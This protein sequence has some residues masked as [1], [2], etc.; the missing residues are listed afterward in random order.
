[1]ARPY[2]L[3]MVND[4]FQKQ[5]LWGADNR[6]KLDEIRLYCG[7]IGL[8]IQWYEQVPGIV[9]SYQVY[10]LYC[11]QIPQFQIHT[12]VVHGKIAMTQVTGTKDKCRSARHKSQLLAEDENS[13]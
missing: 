12:Q 11:G 10:R 5:Q 13:I 3:N 8:T 1:M 7:E 9:E 4:E 6:I 2:C